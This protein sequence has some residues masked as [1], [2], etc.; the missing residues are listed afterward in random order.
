MV[1]MQPVPGLQRVRVHPWFVLCLLLSLIG[2]AIPFGFA[3]GP[4]SNVVTNFEWVLTGLFAL[5]ALGIVLR[6]I[7]VLRP[8]LDSF[9][10]AIAAGLWATLAFYSGF[11]IPGAVLR[12][13]F[14]FGLIFMGIALINAFA[15]VR[16]NYGE[17]PP[18]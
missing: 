16:E 12:E 11:L 3:S 1:L 15:F 14:A 18:S 8:K 10:I 7:G 9:P 17:V 5:D 2:A 13:R 4:R 6:L